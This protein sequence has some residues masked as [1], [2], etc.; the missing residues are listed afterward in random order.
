MK[1]VIYKIGEFEVPVAFP[2]FIAHSQVLIEQGAN[3]QHA[4]PVSAGAFGVVSGYVVMGELG[5]M[6][7]KLRTRGEKDRKLLQDHIVDGIAVQHQ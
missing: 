6:S 2:E 7:L 1:Y 5:S 4:K 3:A